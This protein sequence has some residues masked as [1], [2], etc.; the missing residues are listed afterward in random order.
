MR[1]AYS[2]SKLGTMAVAAAVVATSMSPE[3]SLAECSRPNRWPSFERAAAVADLVVVGHVT[4][5]LESRARYPTAFRLAVDDVVIGDAPASTLDIE[6]LFADGGCV[7]SWLNVRKGDR[8]AI[9]YGPDPAE[10]VYGDASAAAFVS[11]EPSHRDGEM[12]GMRRLSI[13]DIRAAVG[14]RQSPGQGVLQNILDVLS[15]ILRSVLAAIEA[16]LPPQ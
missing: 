14:S 9:A 1:P 15:G 12:P 13:K 6:N 4:K 11:R 16:E 5:I 3:V 10:R 7:T 8:I 2:R